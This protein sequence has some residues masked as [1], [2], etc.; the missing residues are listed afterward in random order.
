[1]PS[2]TEGFGLVGLEAIVTGIP[3]LLSSQSGLAELLTERLDPEVAARVIVAM[4]GNQT[5][6]DPDFDQWANAIEATLRNREASF[7]DVSELLAAMSH[8]LTWK[9]SV[10]GLLSALVGS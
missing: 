5:R 4:T 10:Q 2:R 9:H 7:R 6:P 1:M 8:R 3:V